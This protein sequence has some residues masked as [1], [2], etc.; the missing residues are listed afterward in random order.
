ML[1]S[2]R[3]RRH[4]QPAWALVSEVEFLGL[5]VPSLPT[6]DLRE[7]FTDFTVRSTRR[8]WSATYVGSWQ[9]ER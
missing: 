1:W 6:S 8:K 4:F 9:S 3:S 5:L 7:F 2:S